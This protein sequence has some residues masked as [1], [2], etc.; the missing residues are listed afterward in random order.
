MEVG[1]SIRYDSIDECVCVY[2]L[3]CVSGWYVRVPVQYSRR[4]ISTRCVRKPV[5]QLSDRKPA[6]RRL[7]IAI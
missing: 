7:G 1:K 6:S 3:M 2:V 5:L 4:T